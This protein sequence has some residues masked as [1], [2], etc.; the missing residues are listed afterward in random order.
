M[1]IFCHNAE[2]DPSSI[3]Y[4]ILLAQNNLLYQK[5]TLEKCNQMWWC[6]CEWL[7]KWHCICVR[8]ALD[9]HVA[10]WQIVWFCISINDITNKI[11]VQY[12]LFLHWQFRR[13]CLQTN[14]VDCDRALFKLCIHNLFWL[15]NA[16]GKYVRSVQFTLF[17]STSFIHSFHFECIIILLIYYLQFGYMENGIAHGLSV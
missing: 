6:Q 2:F 12:P 17:L 5:C 9:S 16:Y 3:F 7:L 10:K 1:E 14:C 8:F 13:A 11:P 4:A 15:K